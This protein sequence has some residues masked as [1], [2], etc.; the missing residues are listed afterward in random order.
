MIARHLSASLLYPLAERI[1]GRR[2]RSRAWQLREEM[3]EP[4]A[5]RRRRCLERLCCTLEA[6]GRE[7]P[8]Y[9][10]LFRAR[11]FQPRRV[12]TDPACLQDLPLLTKEI[13][14]AQGERLRR[15][16][17]PER[18]LHVRRTGGSTGPAAIIYYSQEALDWTAAA[19]RLV[20]E[21]AGKTPTMKE[22]HLSSRFPQRFP[23]RDRLR[24]W[25]KCASLNRTNVLTDCFDEEAMECVWRRLRRVRP[26]LVHGH[27]ST[28]YALALHV[29]RRDYDAAGTFQVFE[30]TGE[31]LDARKRETIERAF[32]CRVTDCY[33]NAEFGIVA[34]EIAQDEPGRLIVLD[35]MVWPET[36]QAGSGRQELIFTGLR[37]AA[38]PLIRYRT[39]DLGELSEAQDGFFLRDLAGRVHEVICIDGKAYPTH[40][41]QDILGRI[42]EVVEFQVEE[43]PGAAPLLRLVVPDSSRREWVKRRVETWWPHGLEVEFAQIERLPRAGRRNKFSHIVRGT[44]QAP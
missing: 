26:Y 11:R 42:G 14:R 8:Y 37:N 5:R 20:L 19:G 41:L 1:L 30:S 38:M 13:V 27:P 23:L 39:G 35:C 7:V 44:P 29:E 21:W 2:I 43:R 15:E 31:V 10:E 36:R 16:G 3:A 32:G 12:L 25:V 6:A 4:F 18:S 22:V 40:Y 28:L 9:R 17:L 33:G 24:E 34:Y